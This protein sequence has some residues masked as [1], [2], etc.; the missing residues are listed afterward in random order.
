MVNPI[1]HISSPV[2]PMKSIVFSH[3][4]W[5]RTGLQLKGL[6]F[7]ASGPTYMMPHGV[8]SAGDWALDRY[9]AV[10][11]QGTQHTLIDN[12]GLGEETQGFFLKSFFF[13]FWR[14][15]DG[16]FFRRVFLDFYWDFIGILMDFVFGLTGFVSWFSW[17]WTFWKV[18]MESTNKG[19]EKWFAPWKLFVQK[20]HVEFPGVSQLN[21][22]HQYCRGKGFKHV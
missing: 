14:N 13:G 22:W 20:S 5:P 21:S 10:F 15:L 11:M 4:A 16:G 12:C 7:S 8:P 17:G 2:T 3:L 18:G 6:R 19:L 9:S 1:N